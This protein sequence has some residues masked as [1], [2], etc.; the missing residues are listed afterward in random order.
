MSSLSAQPVWR[1]LRISDESGTAMTA[2]LTAAMASGMCT[3]SPLPGLVHSRQLARAVDLA[4]SS[5]CAQPVEDLASDTSLR[6]QSIRSG[7]ERGRKRAGGRPPPKCV[8]SGTPAAEGA[9]ATH[10]DTP[11]DVVGF[12]EQASRESTSGLDGRS[13]H[14]VVRAVSTAPSSRS[15]FRKYDRLQQ[16]CPG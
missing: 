11:A 13:R 14:H 7:V 4:T 6:M 1:R 16:R 9:Q 10:R 8:E 12:D 3:G 15:I 2:E 5:E